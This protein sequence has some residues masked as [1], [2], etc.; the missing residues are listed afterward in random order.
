MFACV[1]YLLFS[2]PVAI[3]SFLIENFFSK[4]E[5]LKMG[6]CLEDLRSLSASNPVNNPIYSA[7]NKSLEA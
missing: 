4:E 3:L 2:L 7:Q 6:V 5:L 1:A